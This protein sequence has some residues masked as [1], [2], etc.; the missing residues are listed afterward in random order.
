L[1]FTAGAV[2]CLQFS[3]ATGELLVGWDLG[4]L[5]TFDPAT[6]AVKLDSLVPAGF[7]HAAVFSPDGR[8]ILDAEGWPP[9]SARL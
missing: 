3:P 5:Q 8:L 9:F 7:L 6:G 4:I 2:S 1:P